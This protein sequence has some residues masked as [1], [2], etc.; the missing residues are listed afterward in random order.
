MPFQ[1]VPLALE[2]VINAPWVQA[3]A[4]SGSS[5]SCSRKKGQVPGTMAE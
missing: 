5:K 3:F 4:P 2:D 1:A